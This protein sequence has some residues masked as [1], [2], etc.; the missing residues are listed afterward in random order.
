MEDTERIAIAA[1]LHVAL[2]R[3]TG[4]VTDTEWM[5]ANLDYGRA[6]VAFAQAHAREKDDAELDRLALKLDAALNR[7]AQASASRP[8]GPFSSSERGTLPP[9]EAGD[10]QP[11]AAGFSASRLD[12][13]APKPS[14]DRGPRYI[15][16]LR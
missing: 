5:A 14:R 13:A 15:G 1:H 12:S 9:R 3:K 8:T 7:L 6:M 10:T 2:R 16:G 11:P 4:R